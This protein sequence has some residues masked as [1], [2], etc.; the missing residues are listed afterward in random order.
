MELGHTGRTQVEG[1]GDGGSG[2]VIVL[3]A[4]ADAARQIADAF[5]PDRWVR[6]AGSLRDNEPGAARLS[7][8]DAP[9][10][11]VISEQGEAAPSHG[12]AKAAAA[13]SVR[14]EVIDHARDDDAAGAPGARVTRARPSDQ[15]E[16]D[17]ESLVVETANEPEDE[18]GAQREAPSDLP[19]GLA[20]SGLTALDARILQLLADGLDDDSTAAALGMTG[21]ALRVHVS[22][23]LRRLGA[24]TRDEAIGRW[25]QA[26]AT[27]S[28]SRPRN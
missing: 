22:R 12:T 25:R 6:G 13:V 4:T 26:S 16:G 23:I 2:R 5:R 24:E 17:A 14:I 1:V 19:S 10:T 27:M 15:E 9:A 21:W 8:R 11:L 18:T 20:R 7:P 3:M 28:Q